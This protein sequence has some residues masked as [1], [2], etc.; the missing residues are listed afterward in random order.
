M[1]RTIEIVV[2][3]KGETV[4]QTKGFTG[5]SCRDATKRLEEALGKVTQEQLTTEFHQHT[6]TQR[7]STSER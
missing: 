1:N 2:N 5:S 3:P 4:I 7:Q 6:I